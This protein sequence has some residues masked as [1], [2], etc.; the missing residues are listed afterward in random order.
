MSFILLLFLLVNIVPWLL[1]FEW[2]N[3][4]YEFVSS[5]GNIGVSWFN[6]SCKCD[7]VKNYGCSGPS[8]IFYEFLIFFFYIYNLLYSLFKIDY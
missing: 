5:S 4:S 8:I 1:L 2:V 3:I 7:M 6:N